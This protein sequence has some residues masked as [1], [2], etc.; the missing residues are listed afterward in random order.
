[1]MP[2]IFVHESVE[3]N[4]VLTIDGHNGHHFARVLRANE[5]EE[6]VVAAMNGP[7]LGKIKRVDSKQGILDIEIKSAYPPHEPTCKIILIQGLAK[8]DKMD[9]ILQK[10]TEVGVSTI[11]C[12]EARRSV[13][14]I[15]SK[16]GQ[17]IERFHRIALEAA[18][19]AQRDIVPII[20][21]AESV[22]TLKSLL[23]AESVN[24]LILLDEAE[25]DI[26]L[27]QVLTESNASSASVIAI[28]VGPEGGW[29][30]DERKAFH[31]LL[32][33]VSVTLGSRILRTETAGVVA[34]AVVLYH[35][36][37]LGV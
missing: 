32:N 1:M 9:T 30:D 36:S 15:K 23:E 4:G 26:G 28:A 22:K 31:S 18:G 20:Q 17:K 13:V 3:E 5:G 35:L 12:Y 19:Q 10:C 25:H 2:R 29:D 8:G 14:S 27:N 21:Y 34:A 11:I 24:S 37:Q 6:L 33:G 16:E 7:F